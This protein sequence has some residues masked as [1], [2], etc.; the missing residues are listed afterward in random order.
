MGVLFSL[1]Y[2]DRQFPGLLGRSPQIPPSWKNTWAYW[3]GHLGVIDRGGRVLG[4]LVALAGV[5]RAAAGEAQPAGG[6]A[7]WC[8]GS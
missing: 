3:V 2:T 6:I 8:T 5:V 7:R 1:M 4:L